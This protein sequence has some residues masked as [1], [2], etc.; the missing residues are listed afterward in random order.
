MY[1]ENVRS[2]LELYMDQSY[3]KGLTI[4]YRISLADEIEEVTGDLITYPVMEPDV[5]GEN[6]PQDGVYEKGISDCGHILPH[7][8]VRNEKSG[9]CLD[10]EE[11]VLV[12]FKLPEKIVEKSWPV[13]IKDFD[14]IEGI[15]RTSF[16]AL[17]RKE[18][19]FITIHDILL[20]AAAKLSEKEITVDIIFPEL[21]T[22]AV[23]HKEE[24]HL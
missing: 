14:K 4:M 12:H 7:M 3:G 19:D 18:E 15:A 9:K 20:E 6:D 21:I 8:H 1:D 11:V 2:G 23:K 17:Y 5:P 10:D 24:S 22:K 13:E 16:G